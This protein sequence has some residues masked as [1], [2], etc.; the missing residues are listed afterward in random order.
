MGTEKC[1]EIVYPFFADW[2]FSLT[3]QS[4]AEFW[5]IKIMEIQSQIKQITVEIECKEQEL[6]ELRL[7]LKVSAA[8]L[9]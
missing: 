8:L 9:I 1:W 2:S 6:R 5:W 3:L 4:A 7:R